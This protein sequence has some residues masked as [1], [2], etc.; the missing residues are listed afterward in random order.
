VQS[1]PLK[2]TVVQLATPNIDVYALYSILGINHYCKKHGYAHV[3]QRE[4]TVEDLHINWTKIDLLDKAFEFYPEN[5]FI[6]LI[7]ADVII[8]DYNK[9]LDYFVEKYGSKDAHIIMAQDTPLKLIRSPRPNAG[10]VLLRNN[11][12]AKSM[13]K[14]WIEASTGIGAHYND[15][16]PRNQLVYWNYVMPNYLKH[17]VVLPR[18]YFLKP[19]YIFNINIMPSKFLFHVTQSGNESRIEKMN[20]MCSKRIGDVENRISELR[21]KI[22]EQKRYIYLN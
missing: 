20:T 16:H 4:K 9:S 3:V 15:T 10:F 18:F 6:L 11:N 21:E 13:V 1:N 5:D 14:A 17:Q 22:S 7:D 19:L 12:I 2:V 8:S